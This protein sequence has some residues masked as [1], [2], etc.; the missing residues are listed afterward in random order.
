[1]LVPSCCERY[2]KWTLSHGALGCVLGDLSMAG[3]CQAAFC[4]PPGSPA[5]TVTSD[6]HSHP[7]TSC[8]AGSCDWPLCIVLP[9]CLGKVFLRMTQPNPL[10][11]GVHPAGREFTWHPPCLILEARSF[12]ALPFLF[13][14]VVEATTSSLFRWGRS[15]L[16]H[17]GWGE[18]SRSYWN[19][20]KETLTL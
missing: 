17:G 16:P 13:S 6:H 19:L 7:Q 14:S 10:L 1:M 12:P 8:P 3:D 5:V 20:F 18:R 2:Q 11:W 9:G 4:L 15:S